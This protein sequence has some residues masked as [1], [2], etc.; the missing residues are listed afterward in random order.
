M[1]YEEYWEIVFGP[2]DAD[3]VVE[4]FGLI[5]DRQSLSE[6]LSLAEDDA[7]AMDWCEKL[8]YKDCLQYHERALKELLTATGAKW[9]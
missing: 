4:E 9:E 7:V 1:S 5:N 6:W 3:Y 8:T 2:R